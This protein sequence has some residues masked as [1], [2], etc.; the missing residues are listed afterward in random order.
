MVEKQITMYHTV[1]VV[2]D[3]K[4]ELFLAETMI[5]N[6]MF[7][8]ETISFSSGDEA[9]EY[10]ALNKEQPDKLPEVIFVD[11]YMPVMSGFDFLDKYMQLPDAARSGSKII[12]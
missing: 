12:M 4:L 11:I 2:D 6:S 7:A 3:S 1:M 9:L 10:L 5:R 8:K